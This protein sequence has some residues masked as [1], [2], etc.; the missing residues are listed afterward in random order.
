MYIYILQKSQFR[1][2]IRSS[3]NSNLKSN[4]DLLNEARRGDP[5]LFLKKTH[6]RVLAKVSAKGSTK[7]KHNLF[8]KG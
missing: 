5:L 6:G 4:Q 1:Y 8:F 7:E 3:M 2:L